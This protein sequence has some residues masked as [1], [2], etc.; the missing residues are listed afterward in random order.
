MHLLAPCS[1]RHPSRRPGNVRSLCYNRTMKENTEVLTQYCTFCHECGAL[2]CSECHPVHRFTCP[3]CGCG[4][5]LC[6]ACAKGRTC[7]Y[8]LTGI[9]RPKLPD[10]EGPAD[11]VPHIH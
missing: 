1:A 5:T 6:I 2:I 7:H 3:E 4:V 8:C 11:P 9:V 10:R